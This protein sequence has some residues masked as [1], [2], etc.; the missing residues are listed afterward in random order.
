MNIIETFEV[1]MR[2][3]NAHLLTNFYGGDDGEARGVWVGL[4]E[5]RSQINIVEAQ[6]PTLLE[7]L[8]E[9]LIAERRLPR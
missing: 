1:V 7:A 6:A 9:V 4:R 8:T 3:R 2:E 5:I